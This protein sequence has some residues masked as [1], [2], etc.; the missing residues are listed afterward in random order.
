MDP[1]Y[2]LRR[3]ARAG[4]K[5]RRSTRRTLPKG[6][7]KALAPP[8]RKAVTA[9]AKRVLN[10]KVETKFVTSNTPEYTYQAVYGST[11]P[12]GGIPQIFGC[13][14]QLTEGN[15]SYQRKG[16]KVN[17]TRHVTDLRFVFND[18][19]ILISGGGPHPAAQAGW[20]ITIHV[21]YGFAKRYKQLNDA[22][23][24]N[25]TQLL[26]EH[27][28][29]GQ[30]NE[31]PWSGQLLAELQDI[32]TEVFQLKH[33]KVR[34]YKD[35][36]LANVGDT[37]SPSLTTPMSEAKR[38]RL[39]WSPPKTLTYG[40]DGKILPENYAPIII[41]GYCHN[42]ATQASFVANAGATANLDYIPAVKMCKV[43]KLYYKDA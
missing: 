8:A 12:T 1:V 34:M 2:A 21:W 25:G 24:V 17:P 31:F 42:D 19:P 14:P 15:T 29:D 43:D 9:I 32:N 26:Q 38:M 28:Q 39:V 6:P 20:D 13:L 36:G 22:V 11:I 16:N 27:L 3:T 33:K 35:A 30:G 10:R 40:E 41:V 37:A 5:G 23:I 7:S 18:D 4:R